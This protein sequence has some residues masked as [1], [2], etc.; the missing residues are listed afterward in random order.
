MSPAST[1]KH[2]VCLALLL[3]CSF[4][5]SAL[6]QSARPGMGPI[7]YADAL[8]TGT[9]F[10]VWAPNASA[11]GVKGQFNGWATTPLVNE[12]SGTWSADIPGAR[13]NHEYKIRINNSFD[14]RDPRARRVTDSSGNSIVYDMQAFDW[15]GTSIPQPWRN[16]AVIYEMHVGSYNAEDWIPSTFD[17]AIERL[18]HIRDL[19][20]NVIQVMPVNEFAGDRSWGYNP[21]DPFAIES[22][23]GGPN[24]F[25]RFVK[26]C[27]ER[28]IAVFADVVHNHYGPTDLDLWTFD[29]WSQG[30]FGG[31]YFYNDARAYT[32]WGSTR[33]DF[34]RS[35]VRQYI[36]DQ[37]MMFVEEYRLGGFRWDST[38]NILNSDWG[39]NEQGEHM[40]R[41]INWELLQN[42]PYVF[43]ISEDHAFDYSMNFESQW[44][45]GYRWA[46][47]GQV[48]TGSDGDR[49]MYTV[50]GL[51]DGWPGHHR[52]VFSE[53]HDYIARIHGRSRLPTEINGGDPYSIWSRKRALLAAGILM[54]TPGIPMVFQGQEMNETY[55][56]HDDTPLRWWHTNNYAGIVRAYSDL[57]HARRNLRGGT[58]GLKGTGINVHHVDNNNKVIAFVRWDAGG[59]T[60]D[61][62][63]IANFAVT[64]WTNNDY[65]I[66]FPSAG[67][68]YRHFNSDEQF[69]QADFGG[70]GAAQVEAAGDPPAANVNMG[71][72]SLQI[73]SKT[74]PSGVGVVTFDPPSPNG[75][76][77]VVV[78]FAPSNGPLQNATN[79]VLFM[80]RNDWQDAAD[81]Q[82]FNLG[83]GQWAATVAVAEATYE[84]N[85]AF[86]DGA[87]EDAVWDSNGG[88]NWALAISGCA[89]LPGLAA[90][91]PS[92]PQGCVPV[93]ITYRTRE[94]VLTNA[95][96]I[97]VHL[98]RNSWLDIQSL[99]MTNTS[100]DEWTAT[101]TIPEDTWQ[102]DFVVHDGLGTW[103][104]NSG[105]DWH[106][107][108]SGCIPSDAAG[109]TIT[110][111]ASDILVPYTQLQYSVEGRAVRMTGDLS[112]RNAQ[113]DETGS[114]PC[115]TNWSV[116]SIPLELGANLLR[117]TGTNSTVNPNAGARDSA[118]NS[119]YTSGGTWTSG[120]NGGQGWGGGWVLTATTNA[121]H[122]LADT[123]SANLTISP[124]GW[125]LWANNGGLSEAT[126][127]FADYLHV[128]DVLTV[129]CE[130]NWIDT[131]SSV[132]IGLQNRFGQNLFEFYFI[133]GGTNYLINDEQLARNTGIPWTGSGL[134]LT[135]ELTSPTEYHFTANAIEFTGTLAASSEAL[136]RRFRT[137]NQSAGS[138]WEYNLYV[139]E[140]AIDGL[141]LESREH[142]AERTIHRR[143]GP[144]FTFDRGDSNDAWKITF[145]L[146]EIGQLYDI[147]SNTNLVDG[148]W[149]PFELDWYGNGFPLQMTITNHNERLYLRSSTRPAN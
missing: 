57:I 102:L 104:N 90:V 32:P 87:P 5:L 47:H 148:E 108:V 77:D 142:T 133:G 132:G 19:G 92:T 101:H 75:C 27:H 95:A 51:L 29:G 85:M 146:T 58:Q 13:A 115:T 12:G 112:W 53:A 97:Y 80:G 56:F 22:G 70:I 26:A 59:Q 125:G 25:K 105:N 37:I 30:G 88:R 44:D 149:T 106:V 116:A 113:N 140:L 15:G 134:L 124:Y 136:V 86:H 62:M 93:T 79:V 50:K 84:L 2:S 34:G 107:Y 128:G 8:G 63:V 6:S 96:N 137:W 126:R 135:F 46:L 89:G 100:G 7:P 64:T 130:N 61:V 111:P 138:G 48:V 109:L 65:S 23:L 43:R 141:P 49:N 131:D 114:L 127:S 71:M 76:V 33:P 40:L 121:G 118:T 66:Q 73:F 94:G 120:Q 14:K 117:V 39:H 24:A 91:T 122:F 18:D 145:P 11:V 74:P 129:R 4:A 68:W 45:V 36:R 38:Y 82:M 10:R 60:D 83:G 20:I 3:C 41:D 147:H 28:G 1:Q 123:N 72:Y 139:A 69:Y 98:G 9:T 110:N 21:A 119:L 99:T 143:F 31:I 144:H 42:Y 78:T 103:D 67:T 54:T 17:K 16:D 55:A 35:E 81:F 52:V